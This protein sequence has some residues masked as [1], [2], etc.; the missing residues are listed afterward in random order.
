MLKKYVKNSK[1]MTAYLQ[2]I[3]INIM[4][5]KPTKLAKLSFK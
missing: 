5:L 4:L 1:K 3:I 2:S